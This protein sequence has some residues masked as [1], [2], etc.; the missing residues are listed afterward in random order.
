MTTFAK[1]GDY[2]MHGKMEKKVVGI[3]IPKLVERLI[4]TEEAF[5]IMRNIGE[6]CWLT[7]AA[8]KN[9]ELI[10]E[11]T[12]TELAA[13]IEGKKVPSYE[14]WPD[15]KTAM[16]DFLELY[17]DK[18]GILLESEIPPIARDSREIVAA[19]AKKVC[20]PDGE[21]FLIVPQ[22]DQKITLEYGKS[23]PSL[24]SLYIGILG[25]MYKNEEIAELFQHYYKNPIEVAIVENN[26]STCYRFNIGLLGDS[27]HVFRKSQSGRIICKE[28]G[29]FAPDVLMMLSQLVCLDYEDVEKIEQVVV[30]ETDE[31]LKS[32]TFANTTIASH[33]RYYVRKLINNMNSL[34]Q[35]KSHY[36][37]G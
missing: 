9:G 7:K 33:P 28:N 35:I 14:E 34:E 32:A 27:V 37:N 11:L 8:I 5:E 15:I 29:T 6:T 21:R 17:D 4:Q 12:L 23:F 24:K 36:P 20:L 22:G 18:T 19:G 2:S 16:I 25:A 31:M 10:C 13:K 3:S 30:T 26:F 1:T